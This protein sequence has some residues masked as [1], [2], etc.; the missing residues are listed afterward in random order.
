MTCKRVCFNSKQA[1]KKYVTR[2]DTIKAVL[3]D[4]TENVKKV[5]ARLI[6]RVNCRAANLKEETE[7][8]PWTELE[9]KSGP[10][11]EVL[12]EFNNSNNRN[13]LSKEWKKH[14]EV[15]DFKFD[16]PSTPTIITAEFSLEYYLQVSQTLLLSS[17]VL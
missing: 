3:G 12:R 9:E 5:E 2:D 17:C 11:S 14:W 10:K 16:N 8:I 15:K 4:K 1:P 6:S 13:N 7:I